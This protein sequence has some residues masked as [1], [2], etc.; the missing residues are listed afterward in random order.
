VLAATA[1]PAQ[2]YPAKPIRM[3]VPLPP[4][5]ASDLL[6]RTVGTVLSERY[7]QQIVIDNRPGAGG[8]IGS[9]LL[10]KARADGY[11]LALVAA[12]HL[13]SPLLQ[14]EPPYRPLEDITPIVELASIPN[15][16][17]VAPN[18]PVKTLPELI[19]LVK[20]NPGRYNYAS[21][22][23]GTV[24]FIS[25]EILNAASGMKAVHVP[26]KDLG[27]ISAEMVA[28][29]VHYFVPTTTSAH[30]MFRGNAGVRGIAVTSVK[31]SAMLPDL[32]T[33]QE[34]GLPAAQSEGWFGIVAPASLPRKLVAKLNADIVK[35]LHEPDTKEKFARLDAAIVDD[36]SAEAFGRLLKSEF[37][38]YR[39]LFKDSGIQPQ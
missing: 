1:A 15:V 11:T 33:V 3:I 13:A 38:R 14:R 4:G 18:L 27:S 31:R 9:T 37:A 22:G 21:F 6:A 39:K 28:G 12:P 30:T 23:I 35:V 20:A 36:T 16:V 19:A 5:T 24:G 25:A 10:T 32:P 17:V 29:R 26:F 7:H 34:L 2:Q 8:L